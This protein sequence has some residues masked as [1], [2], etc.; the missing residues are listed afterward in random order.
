MPTLTMER[1]FDADP[2]KVF[3][4]VSKTEHLLKWWGPEGCHVPEHRLALDRKGPWMSVMQNTQGQRFKVSGHVTHVDAPHSIGFT[5]AWHDE[6][7]RRGVESHVT[8]K[9]V[10]ARDG[11][12]LLRLS[13]VDLPE[14]SKASHEEG[15]TGTLDKLARLLDA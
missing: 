15:W 7:D 6:N 3:D 2:Q 10:P 1:R 8:V 4:Y 9:L 11:G 14:E 5:W 12:T 13:H